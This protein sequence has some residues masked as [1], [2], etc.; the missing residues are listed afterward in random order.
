MGVIGWNFQV[1]GSARLR[2]AGNEHSTPVKAQTQMTKE[3]KATEN[4][5]PG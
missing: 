3:Q 5:T 2:V 4:G 1:L